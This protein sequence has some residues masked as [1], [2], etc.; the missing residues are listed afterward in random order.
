M[1]KRMNF[2]IM[3]KLLLQRHADEALE[4]I[5]NPTADEELILK[6]FKYRGNIAVIHFDETIMP[7][8]K[9]A[10]CSWNSSMS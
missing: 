3:T 5:E 2:L 1:V 9:K 7:K 6:N 10:W 4:I 8:N